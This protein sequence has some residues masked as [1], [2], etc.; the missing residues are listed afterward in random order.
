VNPR[1]GQILDRIPITGGVPGQ[2]DGST[3]EGLWLANPE[4]EPFALDEIDS[5]RKTVA[6]RLRL[7]GRPTAGP[8]VGE[9]FVWL[10]VSGN[11]I[12]KIDPR[13]ANVV[14]RIPYAFPPSAS[15][16]AAAAGEGALWIAD[17]AA[18]VPG[19]G[20]KFG[21]VIRIDAKTDKVTEIAVPRANG[22]VVGGGAVW[23]RSGNDAGNPGTGDVTEINPATDRV[24]HTTQ[25]ARADWLAAGP[26]AV[27]VQNDLNH[28]AV[29]INPATGDVVSRLLLPQT[30][31]AIDYLGGAL[32]VVVFP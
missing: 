31:K 19:Q 17:P 5:Y 24:I 27:W 21:A 29:R 14:D 10:V 22:V 13:T 7:P 25:L 2:L 9:G 1:T 11:T 4:V 26:G 30:T 15:A 32:S 12:F 23:A 16:G 3:N 8:Y 28:T 18:L 20:L 6:E